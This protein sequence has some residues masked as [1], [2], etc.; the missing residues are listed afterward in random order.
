M[1]A[2]DDPTIRLPPEPGPPRPVLARPVLARAVPPPIVRW[3]AE[4]P[5][6]PPPPRRAGGPSLL[7]ALL[8]AAL[9]L[10]VAGGAAWWFWPAPPEVE[11]SPPAVILPAPSP[12]AAPAAPPEAPPAALPPPPSRLAALPPLLDVAAIAAHRAAAPALLRL[13]DNPAI[14]ILDFPTLEA[15][16][17]ALNRVAA[18]VEKAGMP[19]DRVVSEAALQAAIAAAG[20]TQATYYFGHNYRGADLDRFFR[21]A[22]R[23]GM[24][25]SA[26]EAWV[27][28]QLRLAR[29]LLPEGQEIA[30][31]S[32]AAPG[33]AMDEAA[34]ANI[35]RHELSHGHVATRPAY[36]EH[37]R[38]VWREGFTAAERA[39]F[40]Q[41]LT[42]EGYDAANEEVMLDEAQAYL[43]H[44][45]DPRF[46]T[47]AHVG[48][49]PAQIERLR[50]LLRS[51]AP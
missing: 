10:A 11:P 13:A 44:T 21:L 38:R 15:Q 18:L 50:A 47:P 41:F 28:V 30:L 37:V 25:L 14:F 40:R 16:G 34:R 2:E 23:D 31:V 51:G 43:L 49:E 48:M 12:E 9:L 8:L 36:A 26:A 19:R 3:G 22:A 32:V 33:P 17:A 4:A 7:A 5:P 39:A 20:D 42:R 45:P 35:L 1:A 24:P 6:K 29:G 46:F 27:E